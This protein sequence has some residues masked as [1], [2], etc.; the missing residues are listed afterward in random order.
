M[1][2]RERILRAM[3]GKPVDQVDWGAWDNGG[4]WGS[5]LHTD[6]S[7]A[8]ELGWPTILS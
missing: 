3:A 8:R 2:S 6:L 1:T 7:R 5:W 4:L